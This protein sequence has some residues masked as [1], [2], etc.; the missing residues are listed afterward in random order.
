[1]TRRVRSGL[2]GGGAGLGSITTSG[3]TLTTSGNNNLTF[4][5]NGTGVVQVNDITNITD[6]TEASSVSTA[7]LVIAGG[8]G[9][10]KNVNVGGFLNLN[11]NAINGVI[12]S[13]TPAAARFTSFTSTGT[14][15]LNEVAEVIGSKT[16]ATGTVVHDF[17]EANV[18]VHTGITAN[19]TANFTNVPVTNNRTITLSLI[20]IQGGTG[21]FANAIQIDGVS[22][23]I[24]WLGGSAPTP[25]AN[26]REVQTIT[27]VRSS[28]AW[29]VTVSFSSHSEVLNGSTSALAAPDANTLLAAGVTTS[30]TYWINLPIVGATQV[31][32]DQ[33]TLGG[34]WMMLAYLGS[35]SGIGNTQQ[36]LFHNFGNISATRSSNQTSFC[37]SDIAKALPGASQ[38]T[39][40][41]MWRRTTDSNPILVH[42]IDE[43]WNRMGTNPAVGASQLNF[44]SNIQGTGLGFPIRFAMISN[45]GVSG[46]KKVGGMR[47]EG[48]PSYPGIAWNSPYQENSDGAGSYT[49][50]LNRRSIWYWETN[51]VEANGQ[52]SHAS[53]LQMGPSISATTGQGRRDFEIYFRVNPLGNA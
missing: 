53:P 14:A 26:R 23:T 10:A 47:Y 22:Q 30:G 42:S 15:T 46:L 1:M 36:A 7:S 13:A 29:T 37:R 31:Y 5:P 35:V 18:W 21:R 17:T 9:I 34:G 48:G 52:W 51:G 43:M 33:T 27:L 2:T 45:S 4:T 16:G 12:G 3:S 44:E 39:L 50:Y 19:F 40:Q 28:S 32:C 38:S 41:V 20:L 6:T 25:S 11:G 24:R 8:L 49:E